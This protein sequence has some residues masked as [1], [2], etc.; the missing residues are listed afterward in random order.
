MGLSVVRFGLLLVLAVGIACTE[1]GDGPSATKS[2]IRDQRVDFATADPVQRACALPPKYLA[3]I[4]RG[5]DSER[6]EDILFVPR[7]PNFI[8]SFTLTSHSG[9]WGYLQRIPLVLYGPGHIS[10]SGEAQRPAKITDLYPTVE[11]LLDVDLVPRS[12]HVLREAIV[13]GA[14]PPNLI[15]TIVWDGMGRNTLRIWPDHWPNLLHL[16]RGGV[17]YVNATVG[18]SPSITGVTHSS[19]GT[20]SFPRRHGITGNQ[21][22]ST[23]G[24]L[25]QAFGGRSADDLKLSTF[26][27]QVDASLGNRPKVG[28]LGWKHW[29]LGML[30]HGSG[31]PAGDA[32][33]VALLHY[34]PRGMKLQGL[35]TDYSTASGVRS[36]GDIHRSLGRLDREDGKQ[37]GKWMGHDIRVGP[38]EVLWDTY[39][40]PAWVDYQTDVLL[41]FL[42]RGNYGRDEVPDLAFTNFKMADLAGHRWG[43]ESPETGAVLRA[44][45]SSL[46]SVVAYLDENVGNYV[47]VVTSDHGNTP[48]PGSTGAWPILQDELIT[49]VNE[50][51]HVDEDSSL[52]TTTVAYGMFLNRDTMTALGVTARDVARFLNRY[53]IRQNWTERNLPDGYGDRGGEEVFSAVF[54]GD[55]L[56]EVIRCAFGSQRP[57]PGLDR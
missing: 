42:E 17:S 4:W 54:P 40:N 14:S 35:P 29:H 33:E 43:V 11:K 5:H 55:S 44:L 31:L 41:R 1:P 20:G 6:S 27:D 50:H 34:G 47:L 48:S 49:D 19:L 12:G 56:D 32:D 21:L 16:Q 26:A 25:A 15:L 8:G 38:N 57:P 23:E 18:S 13:G 24:T 10:T 7:A 46:G 2:G 28:L 53:T 45:D 3:R 9:P 22:R 37:D 36:A 51:F 30:G 52:V 39:S